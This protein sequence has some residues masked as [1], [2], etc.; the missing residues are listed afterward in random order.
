ML[1]ANSKAFDEL[2]DKSSL[3]LL[4]F[5]NDDWDAVLDGSYD[6]AQWLILA[7]W[8]V[9]DYKNARKE[10]SGDDYMQAALAIYELVASQWDTSRCGGGVWWSSAR[11]YKNAIT[12]EL[13]ILTSAEG[14]KRYDNQT[15]LENAMKTW[16]WCRSSSMF[17]GI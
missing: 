17:T 15:M 7:Y 8:K 10:S 6:D 11:N 3:G 14:F 5:L 2:A 12:N 13:F 1:F 9:A 16:S 4:A